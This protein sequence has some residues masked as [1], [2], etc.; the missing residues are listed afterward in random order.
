MHLCSFVFKKVSQL[1]HAVELTLQNV[2]SVILYKGSEVG[3][4]AQIQ[5][6]DEASDAVELFFCPE[7]AQV[8]SPSSITSAIG[9]W[10]SSRIQGL[11]QSARC[12]DCCQGNLC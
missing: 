1:I 8:L 7:E 6:E 4:S 5:A 9:G 10:R 2:I 12:C 3:Q 11:R